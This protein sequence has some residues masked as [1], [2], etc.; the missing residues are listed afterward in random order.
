M[1]A[2]RQEPSATAGALTHDNARYN[3]DELTLLFSVL[4]A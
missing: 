1:Q 2:S 4:P 3:A